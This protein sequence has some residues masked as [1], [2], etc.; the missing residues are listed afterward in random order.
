MWS[1]PQRRRPCDELRPDQPVTEALPI[2]ASGSACQRPHIDDAPTI[3][4]SHDARQIFGTQR[5]VLRMVGLDDYRVAA[6]S[7]CAAKPDHRGRAD[8]PG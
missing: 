2:T 6:L 4:D 1:T 3:H 5:G 7:L 8:R